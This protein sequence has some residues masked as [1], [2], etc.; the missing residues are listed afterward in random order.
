MMTTQMKI[1]AFPASRDA[2]IF[3]ARSH[4]PDLT[5]PF[6]FRGLNDHGRAFGAASRVLPI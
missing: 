5:W 6:H 1:S 2:H 4:G 3:P